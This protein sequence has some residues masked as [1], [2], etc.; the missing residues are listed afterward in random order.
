[1]KIKGIIAIA[2]LTAGCA[3]APDPN[4]YYRQGT[5]SGT[6]NWSFTS[7]MTGLVTCYPAR[8]RGPFGVERFRTTT[9][10]YQSSSFTFTYSLTNDSITISQQPGEVVLLTVSS[11]VDERGE[12]LYTSMAGFINY[13]FQ[14]DCYAY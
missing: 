12:A 14:G 10:N 8:L 9:N 2:L 5:V 7:V 1:M 13:G 11:D 6:L 4:G 3:T